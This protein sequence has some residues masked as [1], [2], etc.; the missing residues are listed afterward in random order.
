[1]SDKNTSAGPGGF[2]GEAGEVSLEVE[3][4]SG[5]PGC[6]FGFEVGVPLRVLSRW[7]S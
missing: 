5:S 4:Q 3:L 1:M 2:C 6:F 7:E